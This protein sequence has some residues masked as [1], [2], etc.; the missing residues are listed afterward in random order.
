MT[1]PG[2]RYAVEQAGFL[3]SWTMIAR[4]RRTKLRLY[5]TVGLM[6]AFG[7]LP[8]FAPSTEIAGLP[9]TRPLTHLFALYLIG[10]FGALMASH[11][12]LSEEEEAA[13]VVRAAPVATPGGYLVGALKAMIAQLLIPLYLVLSI[14]LV[15]LSGPA[16][17]LDI[18][19]G[20]CSSLLLIAIAMLIGRRELPFALK[21]TMLAQ[22]SALTEML[23]LMSLASILGVVHFVVSSLTTWAIAL[24]IPVVLGLAYWAL[25]SYRATPWPRVGQNPWKRQAAGAA[26][27]GVALV[28]ALGLG[29]A[30]GAPHPHPVSAPP[31]ANRTVTILVPGVTGT[32]LREIESGRLVWGSGK[33]LLFPRDKA[34]SIARPLPIDGKSQPLRLTAGPVMDHVRL[35]FF[36]KE[37]YGKILTSLVDAGWRLGDLTRPGPA[38]T[39]FAFAYDWRLDNVTTTARLAQQL[40]ALRQAR[41]VERLSINLICQ[42]NGGYICRYLAKYGGATRS[43]AKTGAQP[44]LSG[45]EIERVVLVGTANGGSL[46]ILR[47]LDR[48]RIY[49]PLI[50]R[51]MLPEVLFT[52]P[53]LYQDLPAYRGDL[54]VDQRGA[55][56]PIDLY[57]A[58][59]W[60]DHG[61]SI[62]APKVARRADRRPDLFGDH[63]DR[64]AFLTR[65]LA[66]ARE[67]QGLLRQ[68]SPAFGNPRYYLIQNAFDPTPERAVVARRDR[69]E[70]LY[71][72]GDRWVDKN[73][74]LAARTRAPGDGHASLGSQE[75]LSPQERA[76]LIGD[77]FYVPGGHF[78]MILEPATLRRLVEILGDRP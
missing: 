55:E 52:L 20:G 44:P 62:F 1:N 59:A 24:A 29:C 8:L 50:G 7:L 27:L 21:P 14:V 58:T 57:D 34:Y 19:L 26:L 74:Y 72:T 28:S 73:Q 77:P 46:R 45:I 4:D 53:S 68:D 61:W 75:W 71:F 39:L 64:V 2:S 51:A 49:L 5:P 76:A 70:E 35:L 25:R 13:W 33:N 38:D 69:R 3:L 66:S 43:Q 37:I 63:E 40:E 10:V 16:M 32:A 9:H 31:A 47:E 41:G 36:R 78:E 15:I 67:L 23:V 42:S 11:L 18:V 56:V 17:A 22:A 54:F 12:Q 65:A 6:L 48:G 30:S 60:V